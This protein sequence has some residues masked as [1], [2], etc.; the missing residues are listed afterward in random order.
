MLVGDTIIGKKYIKIDSKE[1]TLVVDTKNDK[2]YKTF[3][4]VNKYT[5]IRGKLIYKLSNIT[6]D[7]KKITELDLLEG[8]K[9]PY[10]GD[11]LKAIY[12]IFKAS[13]EEGKTKCLNYSEK[14]RADK[15]KE[16][17]EKVLK[18]TGLEILYINGQG[19]VICNHGLKVI[20]P[21]F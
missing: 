1:I 7:G 6:F 5:M 8:G 20:E 10:T 13:I 2:G 16:T 9:L 18:E 4:F 19:L 11:E 14:I 3:E 15:V 21:L 12:D 17:V